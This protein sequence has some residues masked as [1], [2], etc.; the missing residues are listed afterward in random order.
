[1]DERSHDATGRI[2]VVDDN[3]VNRLTLAR[4]VQQL[5]YTVETAENGRQALDML[6]A[7]GFDVVLLDIV[8]PEMDGLAVLERI[9]GNA[10]LRDIAV[11]VVSA[12][13]ETD[14]VVRCIEMGAEDYL[15]KPFNPVL[16]AARL[17]AS[18]QKK[19]LRDLERAY[20]DQEMTLRQS[21]KLATLGRLSAGMA[22]E[23]NNPAAA[24]RRGAEHLKEA[25]PRLLEAQAGL[26]LAELSEEQGT[27]LAALG[28]RI[29]AVAASP[30]KL[31][32]VERDDRE[33]ALEATLSRAGIED[34][35]DYA[36]PLVGLGFDAAVLEDWAE[37]FGA[38]RLPALLRWITANQAVLQLVEEVGQGTS[39]I[40]EL[41]KALKSYTYMDQAPVQSVDV[42]EDLNHTLTILGSKLKDGIE[43]HQ[44]YADDLPPITAYGSELNQV[45]TNLI[46]NA[47][48]AVGESGTL[49]LRTYAEDAWVVVEIA[50]DGPGI[51]D[52]VR[53]RIFDPFFTTK[54]PGQGPG[55][56]LNIT[57]N[58]VRKHKGEITVESQPG[59]TVFRVRL[60]FDR[61]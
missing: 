25:V 42:K 18:L 23:L 61:P 36:P 57:Y 2:L 7:D 1:M 34:A 56:G 39:R 11:I 52:E 60:P 12:V 13:E 31:G 46:D 3:R 15:H 29:R 24:A 55:L 48:D 16:L 35:W 47:I 8:M 27:A 9:R 59:N 6:R 32:A 45:W 41:V 22:H 50:D 49:T 43:I 26:A 19:R 17:G 51:P 53:T 28:E 33:S 37:T 38:A 44:A 58:I 30:V 21:E 54:P 40:S 10:A 14:S 20:V 5:G 4:G